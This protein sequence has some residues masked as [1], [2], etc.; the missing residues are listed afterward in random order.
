MQAEDGTSPTAARGRIVMLVD[1]EVTPDSRVQKAAHSAAEAGWEVHL[2]GRAPLKN[3]KSANT[4]MLGK[5]HVRLVPVPMTLAKPRRWIRAQLRRPLAYADDETAEYR[6]R[7]VRSRVTDLSASHHARKAGLP[8]PSARRL[9]PRRVAVK[10]Q[11]RWV[12]LR[13]RQ[14]ASLAKARKDLN[15]PLEKL[16]IRFWQKLLG[17]RCWRV[18]DRSLWDWELAYGKTIDRLRPDII[19]ANDFRMLGVGARATLRARAKGRDVKL[20][21][22]AHE[23]LPGISPWRAGPRWLPAMCA[24]EREYTRVPDEVVTVSEALGDLLVERHGLRKRPTVVLNAPITDAVEGASQNSGSAPDL[25]E[26]CGIGPR[27]PLAV[28]SGAAA[29]QRGLDVM[30]EALPKLPDLHVALVVSKPQSP[31]VKGLLTR[32]TELGVADRVSTLGYVPFDQVVEY[33]SAADFGVIPIHHWPNHEIALI[34]KFFEYSH[35]RLPI[36][37]SDVKAMGEMVRETGQGEVFRAD[38]VADYVRAVE[39]V[40]SDP[41]RYR[42][43]YDSRPELLHEWTW[44]AQAEVLDG[45]YAKLLPDDSARTTSSVPS[46]A[47]A[48]K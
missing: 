37:V 13:E 28:Y 21:W 24:H 43:V 40:L 26:L 42:G 16:A 30:I 11:N 20:V 8:A 38:D 15:S 45:V 46:P 36:I 17:D 3:P 34:T 23:F 39:A 4:W 27:T 6:R 19:H 1:N 22:D 47:G 14:T 35:A 29:A 41:G 7:L 32:A 5:A 18:L 2:I 33:L 48:S 10:F 9:L 31:Y 12:S 25:R 44:E